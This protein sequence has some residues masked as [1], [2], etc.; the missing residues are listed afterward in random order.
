MYNMY[1]R[2]SEVLFKYDFAGLARLDAPAN[3]YD[4]EAKMILQQVMSMVDVSATI[5]ETAHIIK[6]TFEQMFAQQGMDHVTD[7]ELTEAAKEIH[8]A[9]VLS[10]AEMSAAFK[11]K[12][13]GE[14]S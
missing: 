3:E 14:A 5:K 2:I 9:V 6:S 8:Q 4:P 11:A 7:E 10:L 12:H 13:N 1:V